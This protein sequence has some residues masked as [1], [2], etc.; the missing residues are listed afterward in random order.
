MDYQQWV[1]DALR[2][3]A[4]RALQEAQEK[5]LYD[6][7]HFMLTIATQAEGVRMPE[8]LKQQYPDTI[9][10]ILQHEYRNLNVKENS[11]SVDLA[12]K[13]VFYTLEI[14]FQA[15]LAFIDPSVHFVLQFMDT[16]PT[17]AP[18]STPKTAEVIRLDQLRK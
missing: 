14:P 8:F 11:F 2:G 6:G 16:P 7:H 15:L 17:P 3:V 9:T 5:G 4:K 12:F 1:Q 13:G 10:L 18:S